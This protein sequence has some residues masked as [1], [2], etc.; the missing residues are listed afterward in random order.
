MGVAILFETSL[1]YC[2]FFYQSGFV[3]LNVFLNFRET[4][5]KDDIEWKNDDN[6]IEYDQLRYFKFLP[7][8]SNG[9][10]KDTVTVPNIPMIVSDCFLSFYC[11]RRQRSNIYT[12]KKDY[13]ID[14]PLN[15]V[16]QRLF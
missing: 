10:L 5:V 8:S 12:Q 2:D 15:K 6:I 3:L 9:K 1:A 16:K 13:W 4:W 11:E 7:K 14:R